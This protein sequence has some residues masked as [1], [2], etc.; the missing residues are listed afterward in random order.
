[1][2]SHLTLPSVIGVVLVVHPPHQARHKAAGSHQTQ[3][4]TG[5]THHALGHLRIGAGAASTHVD[6]RP[7]EHVHDNR[8]KDPVERHD[9][10][11]RS[12]DTRILALGERVDA[13][14]G[15]QEKVDK[16]KNGRLEQSP[17][18]VHHRTV[19]VAHRGRGKT[20]AFFLQ[21]RQG[22]T[23]QYT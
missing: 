9:V 16:G 23:A 4:P 13:A 7:D 12:L 14:Q 11:P 1:M 6:E 3:Q 20:G 21:R 10:D 5:F 18:L 2:V 15:Q 8:H 22:M 19:A 17:S